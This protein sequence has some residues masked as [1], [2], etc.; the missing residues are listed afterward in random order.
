[1]IQAA[2]KLAKEVGVTAACRALGVPRSSLY[3][4]RHPKPVAKR[5]PTPQRALSQAEKAVVRQEL[6]SERFWDSSPRQVY[7]TLLDEGTYLCHWRTM[8]RIL[9]E[10]TEV[11]ERRNQLQHPA[12]VKPELLATGPNQLWSWDI[13][14]LKGPQKWNHY[15]LYVVMD[16]YSRYIVGWMIAERES[17]LLAKRLIEHCCQNQKIPRDQLTI[18]AD[19][20]SAMRSKT[21]AQLMADMGIV[22]SHSRPYVSN[23]NPYS[24]AQFKTLKYHCSFPGQF[25]CLEDARSFLNGFFDWYNHHHRHSG[26]A[27]MTAADVHSGQAQTLRLQRQQVL[28]QAYHDH[29]ERFVKGMPQTQALPEAVWINKPESPKIE[30]A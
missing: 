10:H 29:P 23:D 2:E 5:R 15:H 20:G 1:M 22:K 8:Y 11:R 7:A 27:M 14:K 17:A 9:D 16:V 13:T 24:E 3:R 6:N 21:V 4:A 25:G 12:Y 28:Q 26:I 18:H 19:R 30:A